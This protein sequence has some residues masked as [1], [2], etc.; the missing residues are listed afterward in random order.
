MRPL[1]V[2]YRRLETS[3]SRCWRRPM[4]FPLSQHR[5]RQRR[6]W[7]VPCLRAERV[8]LIASAFP[9]RFFPWHVIYICMYVCVYIYIYIYVAYMHI[10]MYVYL[11]GATMNISVCMYV[12]MHA[13][14]LRILIPIFVHIYTSFMCVMMCI[15]VVMYVYI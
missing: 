5:H 1:D 11:P 10:C 3:C 7:R 13:C 14:F 8:F 2:K 6:L 12:C 9:I 15:C 4:V